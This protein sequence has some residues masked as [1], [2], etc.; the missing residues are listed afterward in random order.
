MSVRL[1]VVIVQTPPP[2][3]GP[4]QNAPPRIAP[5]KV[6]RSSEDASGNADDASG[7]VDDASGNVDDASGNAGPRAAG[8]RVQSGSAEGC[9]V[10][11]VV[12]EL[13]GLPQIDLMLIDRLE[14]VSA[15]S[16]D[17]LTLESITGDMVVLDW[18][19]PAQTCQAL[20]SLKIAGV[21]WPH[22][23][24]PEAVVAPEQRGRRFY[25]LDLSRFASAT[26]VRESILRLHAAKQV[27]TF[28]LSLGPPPAAAKPAAATRAR[29][30]ATRARVEA[31][32]DRHA[33]A[34]PSPLAKADR[35]PRA[36]AAARTAA[37]L[38]AWVD[39]LEEFDV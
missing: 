33:P 11:A 7:N 30:E 29:E 35:A 16:T 9:S 8:G 17:Q 38:E 32:P 2:Q 20:A 37:Q 39:Q 21:R 27:K 13:L 24:D 34:P 1:N 14:A 3:N 12:G 4:P 19:P 22:R 18:Q 15:A 26:A 25:A 31:E 10:D 23:D 5:A 6:P 28:S 36:A